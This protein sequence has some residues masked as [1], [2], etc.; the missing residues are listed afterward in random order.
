MHTVR[1]VYF[2]QNV[3][4]FLVCSEDLHVFGGHLLEDL[5]DRSRE[6][7]TVGLL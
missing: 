3:Q 7:D 2:H 5:I 4:Q 1:D 6:S